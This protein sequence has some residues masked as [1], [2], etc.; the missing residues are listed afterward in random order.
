LSFSRILDE[1]SVW[2]DLLDD[3]TFTE[4]GN[5]FTAEPDDGIKS[6]WWNPA[7]IPFTYNGAGDHLC[8]DLDPADGGAYAQIIRMWHDGVERT[9]ENTSFTEWLTTYTEDLEQG[10][11]SFEEGYLEKKEEP[12]IES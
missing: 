8:L 2:K 11:Y 3:G 12:T 10:R 9:L 4:D 6:N 1:W 7:W 5:V